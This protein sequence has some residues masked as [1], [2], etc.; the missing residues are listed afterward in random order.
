MTRKLLIALAVL[1]VLILLKCA[2][3]RVTVKEICHDVCSAAPAG[4]YKPCMAECMKCDRLCYGI[5]NEYRQCV[6]K[7]A[8]DLEPDEP[9]E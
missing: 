8:G 5:R 9:Q 4:Q 6:E 7:C 2:G 3:N 1:A